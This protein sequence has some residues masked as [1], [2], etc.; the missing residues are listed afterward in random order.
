MKI[1]FR[2]FTS[3]SCWH[4]Y[5]KCLTYK[6]WYPFFMD[7]VHFAWPINPIKLYVSMSF[8]QESSNSSRFKD[9]CIKLLNF[10]LKSLLWWYVWLKTLGNFFTMCH[11]QKWWVLFGKTLETTLLIVVSWLVI[12][13][14][15]WIWNIAW[16]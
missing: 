7:E 14:F 5:T 4:S 3:L 8:H 1:V 9:W 16:S 11:M 13:G 10:L 15:K 12:T 6:C 2:P